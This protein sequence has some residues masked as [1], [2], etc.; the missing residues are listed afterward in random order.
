MSFQINKSK[1]RKV[2]GQHFLHPKASQII[3]NYFKKVY[4]EELIIEIGPGLG[5][6][7]N[8]IERTIPKRRLLLIEKDSLL[9]RRFMNL[10]FRILNNDA[11]DIPGYIY[12][13][14]F[15][16]SNLP[17][18]TSKRILKHIIISRARSILFLIQEEVGQKILDN[19][20]LLSLLLYPFG[21]FQRIRKFDNTW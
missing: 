18:S 20:S 17:Y 5:S 6:L 3:I 15:I 12:K 1:K 16:I 4:R 10:K 19:R 11:C 2:L 21:T 14:K 7:T 9:I 13:D 8:F